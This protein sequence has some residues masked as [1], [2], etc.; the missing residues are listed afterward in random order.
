MKML[1]LCQTKWPVTLKAK[2][3][4]LKILKK[5]ISPP[6]LPQRSKRCSVALISF[7]KSLIIHSEEAKITDP[8]EWALEVE[9]IAPL[10]KIQLDH[11]HKDWRLH[12]QQL[13]GYIQVRESIDI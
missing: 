8:Q 13:K 1:K 11:D 10:L 4:F 12:Q 3:F 6:L 2:R 5:K 7:L 9:R